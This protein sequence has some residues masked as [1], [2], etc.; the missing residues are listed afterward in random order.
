MAFIDR[1]NLKF[2]YNNRYT[3]PGESN[4]WIGSIVNKFSE[5]KS[6]RL[7]QIVDY[8]IK[9]STN[10]YN[11]K[12]YNDWPY[13]YT[14]NENDTR[15][16]R[17]IGCI[18]NINVSSFVESDAFFFYHLRG[19]LSE[20]FKRNSGDE[21]SL[22]ERCCH[23]IN[24]IKP[25]HSFDFKNTPELEQKMLAIDF[26]TRVAFNTVLLNDLYNS[27]RTVKEFR[28]NIVTIHQT[29]EDN[30]NTL[31]EFRKKILGNKSSI[32][33]PASKLINYLKDLR[34]NYKCEY[35]SSYIHSN[36]IFDIPIFSKRL[37]DFDFLMSSYFDLWQSDR[38]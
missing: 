5:Q 31:Y 21:N 12:S 26:L 8:L 19:I 1:D 4:N 2:K 23:Y 35:L 22:L 34:D 13:Y 36:E 11:N 16:L 6:K 10:K 17:Q 7:R 25:V 3:D 18:T 24:S 33:F 29:N 14:Y 28:E 20:S 38:T 37:D 30:V 15:T 27:L 32:S 9:S